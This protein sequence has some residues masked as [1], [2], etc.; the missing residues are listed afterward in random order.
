VGGS[1][2]KKELAC[3]ILAAVRLTGERTI[4]LGRRGGG[5]RAFGRGKEGEERNPA[6]KGGSEGGRLSRLKRVGLAKWVYPS[7]QMA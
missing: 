6:Q 4:W 7:V 3:H 2:A 5:K 1:D